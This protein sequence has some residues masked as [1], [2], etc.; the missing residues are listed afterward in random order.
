ML[1]V[2]MLKV[3]P[4]KRGLVVIDKN[5]D[6]ILN[7]E[8]VRVTPCTTIERSFL[9]TQKTRLPFVVVGL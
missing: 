3:D 4:M 2:L 5:L 6:Q 8:M 7:L 9:T 1:N